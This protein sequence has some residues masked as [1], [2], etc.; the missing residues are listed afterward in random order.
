[1][2]LR[3][4]RHNLQGHSGVESQDRF[5]QPK[6]DA[7]QHTDSLGLGPQTVW[8]S[9]FPTIGS[10]FRK[11]DENHSSFVNASEKWG[12]LRKMGELLVSWHKVQ[13]ESR[14]PVLCESS[15]GSKRFASVLWNREDG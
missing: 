1:L 2:G 14:S 13:V 7:G 3:A 12:I 5:C 10:G 15:G 4:E 9:P 6:N 8:F 11:H